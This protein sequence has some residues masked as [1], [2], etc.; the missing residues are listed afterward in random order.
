[1]GTEAEQ[2]R[3]QAAVL[4]AGQGH[5]KSLL[6]VLRLLRCDHQLTAYD[7]RLLADLIDGRLKPGRGR[8]KQ[9][10]GH[11]YWIRK[12]VE[13]VREL[14]KNSPEKFTTEQA[15]HRVCFLE[16]ARRQSIA[17][18]NYSHI[19]L[20]P[21]I[22]PPLEGDEYEKYWEQIHTELRRSKRSTK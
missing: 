13:D 17:S 15:I 4:S 10:F 18:Q 9:L 14:R 2:L 6:E 7:K 5:Q 1:M 22:L 20:R 11:A 19:F 3:F 8:P 21:E 12:A 16:C